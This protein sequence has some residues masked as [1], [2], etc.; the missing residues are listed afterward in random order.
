MTT[1]SNKDLILKYVGAMSSF[2]MTTLE[3]L[4]APDLVNHTAIP[5]AQGWSGL[6]RIIR[7]LREAMPDSTL[8]CEDV[9]AEGD[10]VVCRVRMKGTQTG[11]LNMTRLTLPATGREVSTEQIHI[12]RIAC[13]KVVEHWGGRDDFGMLR[14]LGHL[15]FA[16][17]PTTTAREEGR[18]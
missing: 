8:T 4:T 5:E 15:P 18:A 9:I 16:P 10:R 2:D 12:F 3:A 1:P 7:K 13:G 17:S 11:P 6:E 14:Q